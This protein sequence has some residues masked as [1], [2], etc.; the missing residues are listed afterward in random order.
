[1]LPAARWALS[2]APLPAVRGS[3]GRAGEAAS[4]VERFRD[5]GFLTRDAAVRVSRLLAEP[6]IPRAERARRRFLHRL[7][8]A[9]PTAAARLGAAIP[10]GSNRRLAAW[11]RAVAEL[12]ALLAAD[13]ER[14]LDPPRLL[15]GEDVQ[16]LLA[17]PPGR[18]VGEVLARVRQTQIDGKVATREEAE[19]LLLGR[20]P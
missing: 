9:W 7:G 17:L 20:E 1:D 13:G 11:R 10:D 14:I 19:A 8:S 16:R 15:T 4:L 2:F 12:A 18:R 3:R 6:A 5:R